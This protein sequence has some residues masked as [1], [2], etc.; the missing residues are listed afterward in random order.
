M[1]GRRV[2]ATSPVAVFD[3][4][5]QMLHPLRAGEDG[6]AAF[7]S[8]RV[9]DGVV[10]APNAEDLPGELVASRTP[11]DVPCLSAIPESCTGCLP[12]G[13]AWSSNGFATSR[14]TTAHPPI[15]PVIRKAVLPDADGADVPVLLVEV[16][17]GLYVH[18]TSG[19]LRGDW[20]HETGPHAAASAP[21][22][23]S[24]SPAA[25]ASP[26]SFRTAKPTPAAAP[27]YALFGDELRLTLWARVMRSP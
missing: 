8:L 26:R 3:T 17:R 6:R 9:R 20:I 27:T 4:V 1:T 21:D 7:K 22:R 25:K 19:G 23:C 15:R 24:W 2:N 5:D 14:P 11:R 13:W 10:V 16:P 18:R 12:G